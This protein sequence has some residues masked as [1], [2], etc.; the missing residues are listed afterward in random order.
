ME[1]W[2]SPDMSPSFLMLGIAF[3]SLSALTGFVIARIKGS[4]KPFGKPSLIYLVVACIAFAL[5]GF[6]IAIR[7]G[8]YLQYFILF[9][10]L[11]AGL[12]TLHFFASRRWLKWTGDDA[13]WAELLFAIALMLVGC[14]CYIMVYRIVNREG[15][16]L[17][18]ATSVIAFMIPFFVYY[19]YKYAIAIPPK[20]FRGWEYPAHV[21]LQEPDETKLKNLLVIS[22]EF[23]KKGEDKYYTN[24]RAKAPLDMEFG[25]LF[26]YFINDYNERHPNGKI[27]F[28]H[29]SR[30]PHGWIFFKKPKWYTIQTSYIDTDKTIFLNSIKENDVII[31][32]RIS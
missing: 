27:E 12:G 20:I 4:F 25:E 2:L 8:S 30:E 10:L 24:F 18:M 11:F 16:D 15:L 7:L 21:Q 14:I 9:Q 6:A 13:F 28:L 19:T 23:Q 29:D 5:C 26:Y 32:S 1:R 31:C 3:L 17:I 22:F